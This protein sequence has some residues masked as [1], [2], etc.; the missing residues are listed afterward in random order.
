VIGQTPQDGLGRFCATASAVVALTPGTMNLPR[1]FGLLGLSAFAFACAN[2]E[3]TEYVKKP[4]EEQSSTIPTNATV[5]AESFC[6]SLCDRQQSCDKGLDHQTC[7][8]A[9]TNQNA[10]VFP[11]LREDVVNLIVECFGNKDCKTVLQGDVVGTCASEAVASVAPSAAAKSYC[12]KYSDAKKKCGTTVT[13]ATC[14]NSA[15]LYDDEAIAQAQNCNGRP[16]GEIESCVAAA[17]GEIGAGK[18]TKPPEATC[19]TSQ[20]SD[21]G[22]TCSTCAAGSCCATATACAA[23]SMCRSLMRYCSY[24]GSTSSSY[25]SSYL[26]SA[27]QTTRDLAS[28]YFNCAQTK[29]SA[30]C[31]YYYSGQ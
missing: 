21:L 30:D 9:C 10:A 1:L 4:A 15:K 31:S 24:S 3:R 11:K 22:T 12:E 28:A 29:C 13:T 14:L 20:F 8:N 17:F 23:D 27:S 16:C 6:T 26:S 5:S 25:C 2:S 19:S 18:V 7:K